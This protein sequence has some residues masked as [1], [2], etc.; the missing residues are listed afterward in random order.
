MTDTNNSYDAI[1]V[2]GGLIGLAAAV[3]LAQLKLRVAVIERIALDEQSLPAFDGRVSAL[4]HATKNILTGLQ[5]WGDIAAHAE[6][7]TDIL[8]CEEMKPGT[9]HFGDSEADGAPMGY[10]VENRYT[11]LAL[12][13]AVARYPE[14]IEV[15]APASVTGLSQ[16]PARAEVTLE[17]GRNLR[18]KLL[19]VADGKFSQLREQLGITVKAWEYDQT[20]IV[21][22][23]KHEKPHGGLALERFYPAG[24]FAA[25]PM[26]DSRS[27][28]VWTEPTDAA[29]A[30]LSLSDE[31]FEA[32]VKAR[33]GDAYG[34]ISEL[35]PRFS[36]PLKLQQASAYATGRAALVGDTAHA[37]HP[38]AGQG[39]NL[40]YR[41]LALFLEL[42]QDAAQTGM[43]IGDAGLLAQYSRR[44]KREAVAMIAA[45]DGLNRLFSN[46]I[47][48][49]AHARR[50]GLGIFNKIAP[51][52]R[53]TVRYA[54]GFANSNAPRLLKGEA[55]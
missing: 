8:V 6:P 5:V 7:I 39:V 35:T 4:S 42:V 25:L 30:V 17:D 26:Q 16:S 43:D 48:P 28:I 52:K 11:R 32:E 12:A 14:L 10:M 45:T 24:P 54:M 20:A 27:A 41:D 3:G 23:L 49:V 29:K 38:I 2:G 50:M 40:G 53:L 46:S 13:K 1:V 21:F 9:A 31:R 33:L 22:T 18:A 37:V 55:L 51:L 15:L 47:W 19:V 36:Y 34:E 44:R